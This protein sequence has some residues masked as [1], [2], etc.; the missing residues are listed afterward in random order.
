MSHFLLEK[1]EQSADIY[2]MKRDGKVG[3]VERA[4]LWNN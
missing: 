3:R 1:M 4:A 2:I